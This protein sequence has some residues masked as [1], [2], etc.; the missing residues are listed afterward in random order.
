MVLVDIIVYGFFY[1]LIGTGY[2]FI[3]MVT[4]NPR[5]WGYQDYPDRI[6]EKIPPQTR[7]ER[8]IAGLV[9]IPF[10]LSIL[11]YPLITTALLETN[12]GGKVNF[13]VAFLNIFFMIIS[14]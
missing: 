14:F 8:A 2:L 4:F 5:I 1:T 10:F 9:S 11:G 13:E 3:L 6:K 7:R 12:L